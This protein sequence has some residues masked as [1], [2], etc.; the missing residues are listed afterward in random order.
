M[1]TTGDGTVALSVMDWNVGTCSLYRLEQGELS[2][3][4]A[5]EMLSQYDA[6]SLYPGDGS[7]LLLSD[8]TLL[9]SF[10]VNTGEY[11]TLLSWLDSDI[12]GS[13]V[14]GLAANGEDTIAVILWNFSPSMGTS[15]D[16]AVMTKTPADQIP[17]RT[18]LT[19]GALY[20]G[21]TLTD[22][23][24]NFNRTNDTYRVTLVD[25]SAYNTEDDADAGSDQL[26]RDIIAGSCPDI[27]YLTTGSVQKYINKGALA[28][29][30][31]LMEQDDSIS[32]DDLVSGVLTSYEADGK[33]YA[34]PMGFNLDTLVGS[35]KLL[36]DRDGWTMTEMTEIA[37]S[38]VDGVEIMPWFSQS[39]F[40]NNMVYTYMS[41]FVDYANATCS[42]DSE[43]FQQLLEL[44]SQF[45]EEYDY[46]NAYAGDTME[47]VQTGNALVYEEYMSTA[48]EIVYFY[49]LYSQANG[50]TAIG[51][52]TSTGNGAKIYASS[53]VG[54]SSKCQNQAGAWEFIKSLL[55]DE[56]QLGSW[57]L[58][59]TNSALNQVLEEAMEQSYY[60][61]EYGNQQSDDRT[62]WIGDTAYTVDPITQEQ[63]DA[64]VEYVNG[65]TTVATYDSDIMDIVTE[66]AEAYFAG[67]KSAEEVTKL[68]Q[69]RVSIYLGETS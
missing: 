51:Y 63:A 35:Y 52:P 61:D 59:V 50:F 1:A 22:A 44:C 19:L 11:T 26:Q 29:L 21:D 25:Y 7:T 60:T 45:P 65:A 9:Y 62:Y 14:Q 28:D 58:P 37:K 46:D 31:S 2:E 68:I 32:M 23:V 33:L 24:I 18:I 43:E 38:L 10:D 4:M 8:G 12:N 6:A 56:N 3:P 69:N 16:L 66:E 42:F 54:I 49:Q 27:L 15:Y 64:F 55:S 13:S 30:T 48:D 17:E 20:L 39:D 67:D 5:L 40:L 57:Y 34:M 53:P 36:G 47:E 41:D